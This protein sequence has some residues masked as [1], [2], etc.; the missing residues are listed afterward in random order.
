ML[1]TPQKW[2]ENFYR[3]YLFLVMKNLKSKTEYFAL[4]L[5]KFKENPEENLLTILEALE[6]SFSEK[7][8]NFGKLKPMLDMSKPLTYN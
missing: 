5:E 6:M 1:E 8:V 3:C 4:D 7:A 2:K